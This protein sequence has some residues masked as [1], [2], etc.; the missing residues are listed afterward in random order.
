MS[1]DTTTWAQIH[2][3]RAALADTIAGLSPEQW[4]TPSL[5]AG[6][7]VGMMAA[8]LLSSAEQTP[9]HFVGAIVTSGFS[10]HRAMARDIRSRADL[11]PEQIAE[12]LRRRTTTTNKPP[13]P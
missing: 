12:R 2:A 5:C 4:A 3:G 13:A 11:S 6:W 8:H 10:F 9:G 1:D 7:T